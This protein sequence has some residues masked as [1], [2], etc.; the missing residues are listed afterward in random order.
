M[1][2]SI[3]ARTRV[4]H[5]DLRQR[6]TRANRGTTTALKTKLHER[7]NEGQ[8]TEVARAETGFAV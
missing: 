6:S 4:L 3:P 5:G 7:G 8:E 2:D 1:A